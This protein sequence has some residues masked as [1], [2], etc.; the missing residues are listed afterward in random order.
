[1]VRVPSENVFEVA[2]MLQAPDRSDF[3]IIEMAVS[4]K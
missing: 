1:M 3:E 4:A 2:E